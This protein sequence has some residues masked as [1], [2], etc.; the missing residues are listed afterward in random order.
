MEAFRKFIRPKSMKEKLEIGKQK[1]RKMEI[2]KKNLTV[3]TN[4]KYD[5][6]I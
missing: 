4:K 2:Q 1:S 6:A 5:I 3:V